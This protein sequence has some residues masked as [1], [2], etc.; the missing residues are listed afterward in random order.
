V[1]ITSFIIPSQQYVP[2]P[3]TLT[4]ADLSVWQI[5]AALAPNFA[6]VIVARGLGGLSS[7]GGSVT[8]GMVADL[9]DPNEQQYAVAF[10]VFSSV[11]GS[12]IGPLV[13]PFIQANLSW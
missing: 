2:H 3:S 10:I 5:L 4:R 6:T 9:Y 8:L 1:D 11:F 13:G 7:A 12:V